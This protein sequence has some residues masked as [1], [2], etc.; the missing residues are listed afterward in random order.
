MKN[1]AYWQKIY[2]KCFQIVASMFYVDVY[3]KE[4]VDVCVVCHFYVS[5]S[6]LLICL[7]KMTVKWEKKFTRL[8]IEGFLNQTGN[9]SAVL[10]AVKNHMKNTFCV[11]GQLKCFTA[12]FV[13][14][15]KTK[16]PLKVH[17]I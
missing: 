5:M 2:T 15:L 1:I 3:M 16:L 4:H 7:I 14:G 8:W 13:T 12:L 6:F 17:N 9:T 11:N 10:H